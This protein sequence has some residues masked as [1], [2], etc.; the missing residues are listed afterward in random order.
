MF[1]SI[2]NNY[3]GYGN[4]FVDFNREPITD[5][6]FDK[7]TIEIEECE[8]AEV[9]ATIVPSNATFTKLT[10]TS[11]NE[12]VV[13]QV[14]STYSNKI[15]VTSKE[16]FSGTANISVQPEQTPEGS[17]VIIKSIPVTVTLESSIYSFEVESL[18]GTN[19]DILEDTHLKLFGTELTNFT[20]FGWVY[21]SVNKNVDA[22]A[23][24]Y[25]CVVN[26]SPWSGIRIDADNVDYKQTGTVPS[27]ERPRFTTGTDTYFSMTSGTISHKDI[28]EASPKTADLVIHPFYFSRV[29]PEGKTAA[30]DSTYCWSFDGVN[31]TNFNT[32]ATELSRLVDCELTVGYDY[33]RSSGSITTT[34]Y[35]FLKT[36]GLSDSRVCVKISNKSKYKFS[37]SLKKYDKDV[38]NIYNNIVNQ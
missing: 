1:V 6:T 28:H 24:L 16:G 30:E 23:T 19:S 20:L 4:N 17:T 26:A 13:I 8:I 31:W 33:K 5:I 25:Q 36:E 3:I 22:N 37:K 14:D 11:D 12:N 2:D 34:R 21:G 32:S 35:R 7:T 38:E 9:T 18:D 29:T 10:W 27:P 15:K